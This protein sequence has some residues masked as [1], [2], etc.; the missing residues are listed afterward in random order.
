MKNYKKRSLALLLAFFALCM[1]FLA[2]T[3][4]ADDEEDHD[5]LYVIDSSGNYIYS[6]GPV[7]FTVGQIVN[8]VAITTDEVVESILTDS[9][10]EY[11]YMATLD[12]YKCY[13]NADELQSMNDFAL[14]SGLENFAFFDTYVIRRNELGNVVDYWSVLDTEVTIILGTPETIDTAVYDTYII[15]NHNGINTVLEDLDSDPKTITFKTN[16][17]GSF[18]V[19]CA[20]KAAVIST[21]SVSETVV[22]DAVSTENTQDGLVLDSVPKTG[23][24]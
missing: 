7:N 24:R 23:E 2:M 12:I 3:I 13:A 16:L 22:E 21:E 8:A 5:P 15:R 1:S 14:A 11:E 19:A 9:D 10:K 20:P 18:S 6:E 4:L 17:F